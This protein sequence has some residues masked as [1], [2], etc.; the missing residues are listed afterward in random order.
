MATQT[1]QTE[2]EKDLVAGFLNRFNKLWDKY[3]ARVSGQNVLKEAVALADEFNAAALSPSNSAGTLM[4]RADELFIR[5]GARQF[6]AA[7]AMVEKAH[8]LAV[9]WGRRLQ[10]QPQSPDIEAED[11]HPHDSENP[12]RGRYIGLD[13][14]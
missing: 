4:D 9:A 12:D 6:P 1:E 11:W 3:R 13:R 5:V 14:K 8:R 10:T 7:K 2:A